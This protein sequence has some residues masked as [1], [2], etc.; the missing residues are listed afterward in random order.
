MAA[1]RAWGSAIVDVFSSRSAT[2]GRPR[3]LRLG[4]PRHR[5]RNRIGSL[6]RAFGGAGRSQRVKYFAQRADAGA[7]VFALLGNVLEL[8]R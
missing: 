2:K 3:H 7:L 5:I 8:A 1:L 6:R 4:Q